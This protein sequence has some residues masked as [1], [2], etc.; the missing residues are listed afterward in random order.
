MHALA[1]HVKEGIPFAQD[2]SLEN[3]E[4]SYL[5]SYPCLHTVFDA[6]SSKID[7]I[8]LINPCYLF[9]CGDLNAHHKN[10]LTYSGRSDRPG[11]LCYNFRSQASLGG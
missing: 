7:K 5:N 11:E 9:F 3:S 4:N 1:V 8:L 2:L 6:I 10:W